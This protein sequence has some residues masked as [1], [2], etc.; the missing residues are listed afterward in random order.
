MHEIAAGAALDRGDPENALFEYL[1][2]L[3]GDPGNVNT[4]TMVGNLHLRAGRYD[5]AVVWFERA[6]TRISGNPSMHVRRMTA[7]YVGAGKS[8]RL[9]SC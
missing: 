5:Q 7:A 3:E 8:S 2:Q 6:A 1:Q 4:Q 9:S